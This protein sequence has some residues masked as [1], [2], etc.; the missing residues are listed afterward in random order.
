M[1]SCY[2]GGKDEQFVCC[3][4]EGTDPPFFVRVRVLTLADAV[5]DMHIWDRETATLL[6]YIRPMCMPKLRDTT[7]MGWNNVLNGAVMFATGS[8]DGKVRVWSTAVVQQGAPGSSAMVSD[9]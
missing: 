5:G 3:I 6:H 2:F 8:R 9:E 7:C 1:G 4:G